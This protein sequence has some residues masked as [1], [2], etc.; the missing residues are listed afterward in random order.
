MWKEEF[1]RIFKNKALLGTL[2]VI[3]CIPIFY[4][5]VFLGSVWDP[6]NN[7]D[8]IK[9]AVVNLDQ[10][11]EINGTTLDVGQSLVD[12]LKD[13][14]TLDF[15]PVSQQ[16]ADDGIKNGTYY[17]KITIPKDFSQNATTVLDK[18]PQQMKLEYEN[19]P[20]RNFI[21]GTI[22]ETAANKVYE[23]IRAQIT[24]TYTETMFE[25][26]DI[27]G[28]S[29][30]TAGEGAQK[31]TSGTDALIEG[32]QEINQNL[33][34]LA[35]SSL[36][37]NNGA[38]T[39]S[40]GLKTYVDG[41]LQVNSGIQTFQTGI[42]ALTD[43]I[44]ILTTGVTQLNDGADQLATGIQIY[45]NGVS[46]THSGAN[47]LNQNSPAL[48]SGSDA[49]ASNL[50]TLQTQSGPVTIAIQQLS[51]GANQLSD[52]INTDLSN[53]AQG[54]AEGA[55]QA[56]NGA[57]AVA[58][59]LTDTQ[60]GANQLTEKTQELQGG[61]ANVAVGSQQVA[62][63]LTQLQSQLTTTSEI[64]NI[65][66]Q[67][68]QFDTLTSEKQAALLSQI[69]E[70]LANTSV[71]NNTVE[72]LAQNSQQIADGANQVNTATTELVV[73]TQNLFNGIASLTDGANNLVQGTSELANGSQDLA[74]GVKQVGQG[75]TNL[76]N[77]LAQLEQSTPTLNAG[78]S[79]LADGSNQLAS[80]IQTYTAAVNSLDLGLNELNNHSATLI[81]GS[82]QLADGTKK[83]AG[84][85]P[86]L[87]MGV[88]QLNNGITKLAD[89]SNQLADN[90]D[91][92]ITGSDALAQ[93][94]TAISN[95]AQQLATGSLTLGD[96]LTTLKEGSTE[97]GTQLLDGSQKMKSNQ[98]TDMGLEMFATPVKL[99][100]K[101]YSHVN[102]Y[103]AGLA[104]YFLSVALFVGALSFNVIYPMG[105]TAG[106]LISVKEWWKSKLL[107]LI[108][109]AILQAVILV[110]IM[111]F[112]MDIQ[113]NSLLEFYLIAIMS[114]LAS[115][116]LVTFL[117]VAF[118]NVG[119]GLSMIFL[120]LQLGSSAGTFPLE[121]SNHFY[122]WLNPLF[123]ITYSVQGLRQAFFGGL[124]HHAFRDNFIALTSFFLLFTLLLYLTYLI[125]H[126]R[127][128]VVLME[129]FSL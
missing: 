12:N 116:S 65:Q 33:N 84:S 106:T 2:I 27:V 114:S 45:T 101:E 71:T 86:T 51:M 123:P 49:L 43:K 30:Q 64:E 100:K 21:S 26:L 104:P 4:G 29:M 6:Y 5:S 115:M 57:Q 80:S 37:F 96:G 59:G 17:M 38:S 126:K 128:H 13:N 102:N 1:Q 73:G 110:T 39:L 91:S 56:N 99:N 25:A 112:V 92:L 89:G 108:Y 75:S 105:Q 20:G 14:D 8:K 7:L 19:N 52:K 95:G 82:T 127:D 103:G 119:K 120:V 125:K 28:S 58:D 121:T 67:I 87:T 72:T 23:T 44:P 15:E 122:Q 31:I 36:E 111:K 55:H 22:T 77:Q 68:N 32:N 81:T 85:T 62:D 90:G 46:A 41:V 18:E 34:K 118:G 24:E 61:T 10:P 129:D 79:Q 63:S 98:P 35:E 83:L 124:G 113:T 78:V 70:A 54:I 42:L 94:A 117:N 3:A 16:K 97:L 48:A 109:Q 93:G 76:S 40:I 107:V 47:Q 9:V 66:T 60:V 11:A 74:D 88:S 53:G 50:H 69:S